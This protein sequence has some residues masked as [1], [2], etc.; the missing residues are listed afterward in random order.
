MLFAHGHATRPGDE[1]AAYHALFAEVADRSL[2]SGIF[3]HVA[4]VPAALPEVEEAWADLGFGR[5][6]AVAAR[7]TAA[8]ELDP[9]G[10]DIRSGTPDDLASVERLVD[11]ESR[12]HA[13][14]PIFRPYVSRD[15]ARN[16]REQ[17]REALADEEQ[18]LF[19]ARRNG[20]DAGILSI[21]PSRGSPLYVPDDA[22]YIGD[23][24]VLAGY[25]DGGAGTALLGRALR[26]ARERGFRNVTLHY[27]PANARSRAFWRGH[28]FQP[29]MWHMRRTIDPRIAWAVPSAE[30]Q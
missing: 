27:Q 9:P 25:R 18:A 17:L 3:D 4:H 11:E 21:G 2:K 7:D 14:S 23:T 1:A 12:F 5:S 24:A 6:A 16:V 10:W 30:E 20:T 15:V 22:C 28:G 8:L 13:T 26:W 19:I 29:V